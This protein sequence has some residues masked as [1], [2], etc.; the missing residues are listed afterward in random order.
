MQKGGRDPAFLR[1]LYE[2]ADALLSGLLACRLHMRRTIC[3]GGREAPRAAVNACKA[4]ASPNRHGYGRLSVAPR[5]GGASLPPKPPSLP[6]RAFIFSRV[7]SL[8][9]GMA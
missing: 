6:Q 3:L 8:K 9:K 4:P 1:C 2:G 5:A 7:S